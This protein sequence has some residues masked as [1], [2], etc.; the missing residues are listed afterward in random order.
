[1]LIHYFHLLINP[2]NM[3]KLKLEAY[4]WPQ[5]NKNKRYKELREKDRRVIELSSFK[6]FSYIKNYWQTPYGRFSGSWMLLPILVPNPHSSFYVSISD[7]DFQRL[8]Q[9]SISKKKHI[10]E[11][12][13]IINLIN[14]TSSGRN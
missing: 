5:K 2:L 9:L 3:L 4:N 8:I 7:T 6:G 10:G 12:H 13:R 1:M 14:E 11:I